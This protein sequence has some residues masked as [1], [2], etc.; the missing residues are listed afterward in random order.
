MVFSRPPPGMLLYLTTLVAVLPGVLGTA[1][2]GFTQT[3]YTFGEGDG[4]VQVC[5]GVTGSISGLFVVMVDVNAG[6]ISGVGSGGNAIFS[7]SMMIINIKCL[8]MYNQVV[9]TYIR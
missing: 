9:V 6:G 7:K 1:D 5:V 8:A 3:S 2:V 4:T